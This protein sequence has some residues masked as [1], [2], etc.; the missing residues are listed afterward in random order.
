L[1]AVKSTAKAEECAKNI[2][3]SLPSRRDIPSRVE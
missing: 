3:V 1:R 2:H